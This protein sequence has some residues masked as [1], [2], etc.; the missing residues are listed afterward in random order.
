M[1][2]GDLHDVRKWKEIPRQGWIGRTLP[3]PA[4]AIKPD[5]SLARR[6]DDYAGVF[7]TS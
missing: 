7:L 5:E 4:V 3:D 2:V 1:I 6:H